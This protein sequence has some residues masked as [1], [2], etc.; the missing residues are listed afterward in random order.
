MQLKR[1]VLPAP[2]GPMRPVIAPAATFIETSV[3]ALTPPKDFVTPVQV[4]PPA[5]GWGTGNDGVEG[6]LGPSAGREDS[7]SCGRLGR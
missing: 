2:F 5:P 6:Q 4:R 3:S 7:T 1:V